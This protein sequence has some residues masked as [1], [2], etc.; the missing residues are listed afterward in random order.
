MHIRQAI[1]ENIETTITGLTT[2]G[3]NVYASRVYPI[4][5]AKLP[6]LL[7][8]TKDET[9]EFITTRPPRQVERNLT[10]TVEAYVRAA[11]NSDDTLDTIT[12]E[13]EAALATDITRGGNA[14]DTMITGV[15]IDFNGDGDLPVATA[16]LTVNVHYI[17]MEG[18]AEVS[19]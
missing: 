8:Y 15:D 4:G 6:C 9:S 11:I 14:R 7:V 19:A 17:T 2:T 18:N 5:V 10:V 12:A 1:R 13:V 3:A 16:T